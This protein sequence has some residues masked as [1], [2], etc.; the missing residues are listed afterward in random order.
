MRA[1]QIT[2]F[3][4]EHLR[5]VEVSTP[6]P[7]AGE[8]LVRVCATSLNYRDL[9]MVRGQYDPRLKMPRIPLSDGA[10]EVAELGEGVTRFRTGDR[11]TGL[12]LQNW[13]EGAPSS[14]K[15][16]GALGG[17]L[18]G[19]LAEYVVLPEKGIVPIPGHL[20]YEQAETLPC[21]ALT[22]WHAL[23]E[24]ARVRAGQTVVI[25]GTG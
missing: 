15:S 11:V 1:Y 21:S 4:L 24:V 18:D 6:V 9:M 3:G 25:Q 13:Q 14:E 12:F 23:I 8:V 20:S 22:A 5:P 7:G 17:D 16:R 19:M 2:Q 10:G